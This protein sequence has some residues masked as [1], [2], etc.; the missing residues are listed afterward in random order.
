MPH[1]FQF[2][3]KVQILILLFTFF[4]F[5]PVVSR[6]S[7]VHN[8]ASSLFFVDYYK[9]WSSGWELVIYLYLKIPFSRADS[10]L[11]IYHLFAWSSFNFLHNSQ[12]I[13]LPTQLYLVLYS[14]CANLLHLLNMWL[15]V[16]SLSPHNL[17][18]LFCCI[19]S[20]LAFIWL[21]LMA[22]FWAAIRGDSVSLL[23]FPFLSHIHVFLLL[24]TSID[25][26]SFPFLFSGYFHSVDP[27]VVSIVSGGSDQSSSALF[28]V[29]FD[30]II[31]NKLQ[32]PLSFKL[33]QSC[34]N[35]L[36]KIS[37]LF[38][39]FPVLQSTTYKNW[40]ILLLHNLWAW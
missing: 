21:V 22:L 4:E 19:L 25:L 8:S 9:V 10:W 7:K 15:I 23:R 16:L 5:Y 39:I 37:L 34:E 24:K 36:T 35:P 14:F 26:F 33:V 28:Y 32:N 31:I 12:W 11:C 27:C 13:T 29:I 18:M 40:I 2:P 20:I 1:F 17:H 30:I 3:S 6:D 38:V